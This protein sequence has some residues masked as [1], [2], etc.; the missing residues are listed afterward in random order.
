MPGPR[1][2]PIAA[3]AAAAVLLLAAFVTTTSGAAVWDSP[4]AFEGSTSRPVLPDPICPEGTRD[5]PQ[6]GCEDDPVSDTPVPT[7]PADVNPLVYSPLVAAAVLLSL[8]VFRRIQVARGRRRGPHPELR[9]GADEPG[10]RVVRPPSEVADT[11]DARLTSLAEGSPRNAVVAAWIELEQ[12]T[13]HAGTVRRPSETSTELTRRALA[14][15]A[16]DE[17]T[18]RRLAE[19]YREARFSR[20]ELTEAHRDEAR[21]CLERL[22]DDLRAPVRA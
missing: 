9:V 17:G 2:S 7:G 5:D 1:W 22:R 21:A 6:G 15:Y 3:T 11:I 14:A 12:A 19:L 16:L 13:A 4:A 10:R 20:H 8:L 18:I